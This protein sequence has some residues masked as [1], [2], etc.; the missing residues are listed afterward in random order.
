VI[1]NEVLPAGVHLEHDVLGVGMGCV[2]DV[3][4]P[5]T[6]M[7]WNEAWADAGTARRTSAIRAK[8][9]RNPFMRLRS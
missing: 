7:R 5:G 4:L 6:F 9:A 8:A 1:L 3:D 2:A